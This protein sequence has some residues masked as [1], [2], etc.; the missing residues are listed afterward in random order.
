MLAFYQESGR[1]GRDGKPS[2]SILYFDK[3][4][5]YV[6]TSLEVAAGR[7]TMFKCSEMHIYLITKGVEDGGNP[8]Q[9]KPASGKRPE[10]V[11]SELSHVEKV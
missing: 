4:D 11:Q 10:Q 9:E 6:A 2:V 8:E 5:V 7:L 1:A 3:A